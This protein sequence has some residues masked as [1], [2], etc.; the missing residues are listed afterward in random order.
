LVRSS[1]FIHL[2]SSLVC[3]GFILHPSSLI[4]GLIMLIVPPTPFRRK[5]GRIGAPQPPP[6]TG[7]VIINVVHGGAHGDDSV[8]VTINGTVTAID[9]VSTALQ[10][11]TGLGAWVSPLG[12]NIDLQPII[13]FLFPENVN[14]AT[15]W[16]VLDPN[17]WQFVGGGSLEE[18]W[19]GSV[20]E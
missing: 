2:N 16:R 14:E 9:E 6:I 12:A 20:G 3:F 11:R 13:F 8:L 4:L 7:N 10:V 18:P 5:R 15:E 19:E 17:S 1:S